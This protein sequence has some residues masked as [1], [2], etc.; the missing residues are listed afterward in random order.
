MKVEMKIQH[1]RIL[2]LE[3]ALGSKKQAKDLH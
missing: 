3:E 2:E 1:H